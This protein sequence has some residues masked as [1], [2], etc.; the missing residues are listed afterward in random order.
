MPGRKKLTQQERAKRKAKRQRRLSRLEAEARQ[1]LAEILKLDCK[2]RHHTVWRKYME[3]WADS[4]GSVWCQQNGKRHKT[5]TVNLGLRNDFY[6]LNEITDET[7]TG[8]ERLVIEPMP[9]PHDRD[10]ARGWI[11]MFREVFALR[12]MLQR[13]GISDADIEKAIDIKVCNTEEDMHADA[14]RAA[15]D[16]LHALRDG[17]AELLSNDSSY[18][19]FSRFVGLQYMRTSGIAAKAIATLRDMP[20]GFDGTAAWGLIR[21]I[22]AT[23]IGKG[24]YLGRK[25]TRLRFLEADSSVEFITGD[26]PVINLG[27]E[28]SLE[29]YYPL[30]PG[31]ALL[32]TPDQVAASVD[33]QMISDDEVRRY[34]RLIRDAAYQQ[35]YGA[36][37]SALEQLFA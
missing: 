33:S 21:T 12:D 2:R 19:D 25:Q 30:T 34:N 14:E 32:L 28:K 37:E 6:R 26:Q 11:P 5:G 17:D 16:L 18:V 10:I 8:I 20:G 27:H 4:K 7:L 35:L 15:L 13:G 29:L 23:T 1:A 22:W 31:R 36:S 9:D 24:I 3:A